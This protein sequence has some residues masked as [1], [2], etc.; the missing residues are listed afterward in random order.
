MQNYRKRYVFLPRFFIN[1][2]LVFFTA[3]KNGENKGSKPFF[4]S[5]PFVFPVRMRLFFFAGLVAALLAA[6]LLLCLSAGVAFL[7][8]LVAFCLGTAFHTFCARFSVAV[9]L[10][11]A[12]GL[13]FLAALLL[14]RLLCV[15]RKREHGSKSHKHQFLHKTVILWFVLLG[16]VYRRLS[17]AKIVQGECNGKG[18]AED[19]SFPLPSRRL[20]YEK[21]VQGE[22]N[23]KGK[24]EDF[25]F[26]LPSRSLRFRMFCMFGNA[27]AL[28]IIPL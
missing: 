22:C 10:L 24:A 5:A 8:L 4:R 20:F 14:L 17:P 18:K 19:F 3:G 6:L 15:D 28:A 12:F 7:V 21:I 13:F 25:S 16:G 11:A 23:G 26:P 2:S 1:N 27:S 9:L